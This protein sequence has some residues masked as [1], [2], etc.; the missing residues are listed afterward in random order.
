MAP[1]KL[2]PRKANKAEAAELDAIRG[3]CADLDHIHRAEARARRRR[4]AAIK[5][6]LARGWTAGDISRGSGVNRNRARIGA[7]RVAGGK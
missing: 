1:P 3:A 7:G 2:Q 5:R 4:D 6:L